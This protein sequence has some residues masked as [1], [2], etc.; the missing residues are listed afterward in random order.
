MLHTA[1]LAASLTS[2]GLVCAIYFCNILSRPGS[3]FR[4][5]MLAMILL[6]LLTGLFPL[7]FAASLAGLLGALT[8]GVTLAAFLSAGIDLVSVGAVIATMIMFRALVK[9]T[10]RTASGPGTITPLTPRP[11]Q[12]GSASRP[13]KKAA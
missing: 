11:P 12:A 4:G 6:S 2:L 3:W 7:A 13:L 5:E 10:Y 9:A 8:G 1:A